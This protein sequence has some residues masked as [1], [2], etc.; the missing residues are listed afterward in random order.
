MENG[1]VGEGGS[2]DDGA[3]RFVIPESLAGER[4]D[5]ALATLAPDGSG[6]SRSRI[7]TLIE[8][9]AAFG[10][11]GANVAPR[12]K[13]RPG[14]V[15]RIVAPPPVDPVPQGEAIPLDVLHEDSHLI[16][17]NKLVGMVVHPAP[18]APDGTLV[19][20][21]IAHCGD[22][23][24]G[25]GGERR[26]GI[27]HRIDKNTSGLLVVAKTD[28]A[29]QGLAAQFAAH[30]LER[31]S[32]ALCWGAP[33]PGD[34]R[35]RGIEGLSVEK[36]GW[37]RLETHI[38]RH[39]GDRKKMAATKTAGRRAVT[40]FRAT[41]TFGPDVKPLAALLECRLETG[42]TH[43]IRVHLTHAGHALIG[44]P[45]YGRARVVAQKA[46]SEDARAAL[47]GFS[48]QAL[49]AATL[50]FV[51]PVSGEKMRFSAPPPHDLARL[52][53]YLRAG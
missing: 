28:A 42:R 35:L 18:G 12:A 14:D 10:P 20:A 41:E 13:V 31:A 39:R 38:D 43:Q 5:K 23:L 11:Q 33:D 52:L 45:V 6:L 24:S 27:V 1:G 2:G 8:T 40:R 51:H 7:R 30:D 53:A 9:G 17:V 46:L 44:D 22:S 34:P 21:L 19:N 4:L 26:P 32:L 25:I 48:R 36:G 50:G 29:H 49:H 37:L 15:W 47:A 16:V 3:F